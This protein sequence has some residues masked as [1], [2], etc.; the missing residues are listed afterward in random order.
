M[1]L[2]LT[3]YVLRDTENLY[4]VIT[5]ISVLKEKDTIHLFGYLTNLIYTSDRYKS[6]TLYNKQENQNRHVLIQ[7]NNYNGNNFSWFC[8]MEKGNMFRQLHL[9]CNS[10]L[11]IREVPFPLQYCSLHLYINFLQLIMQR[12]LAFLV[13]KVTIHNFFIYSKCL[14][15]L[16]I[17][18]VELSTLANLIY[19]TVARGIHFVREVHF[20]RQIVVLK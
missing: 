11:T 8:T 17:Y 1:Q 20:V 12:E 5:Y 3:E 4:I 10:L 9:C 13:W 2:S 15:S 18:K 14:N 16:W 19:I 6:W 7:E